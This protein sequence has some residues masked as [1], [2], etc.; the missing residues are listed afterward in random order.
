MKVT[1]HHDQLEGSKVPQLVTGQSAKP[2]SYRFAT[3]IAEVLEGL[4]WNEMH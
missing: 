3:S 4:K 2:A 1:I